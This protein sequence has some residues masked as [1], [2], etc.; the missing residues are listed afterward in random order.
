LLAV[1]AYAGV[2]GN[3]T[4][5]TETDLVPNSGHFGST[6]KDSSLGKIGIKS[7]GNY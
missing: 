1:L 7:D 6:E 2:N 5:L 3:W 4:R